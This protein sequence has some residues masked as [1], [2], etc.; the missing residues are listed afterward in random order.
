LLRLLRNGFAANR[1]RRRRFCGFA[2]LLR[3][4]GFFD[5][6]HF[7][8][9]KRRGR[10]AETSV[11]WS[12]WSE[13]PKDWTSCCAGSAPPAQAPCSSWCFLYSILRRFTSGDQPGFRPFPGPSGPTQF[14]NPAGDF[15]RRGMGGGALAVASSARLRA[16]LMA[17]SGLGHLISFQPGPAWPGHRQTCAHPWRSVALLGIGASLWRSRPQTTIQEDTPEPLARQVCSPAEQSDQHRGLQ[18]AAG[19][20]GN[21]VSSYGVAARC[22]GSWRQSP[23]SRP[24]WR[25][26]LASLLASSFQK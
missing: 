13:I 7:D 25:Q 2:A 5:P 4:G 15:E 8:S 24:C 14:R 10:N 12:S 16:R 19:P 11:S 18:P 20:G 6:H 23:L 3:A 21:G 9:R 22:S 1:D 26:P 17:T